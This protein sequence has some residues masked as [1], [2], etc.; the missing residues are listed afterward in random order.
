[1]TAPVLD[2]F[3]ERVA[4]D[5]FWKNIDRRGPNECWPWKAGLMSTGYGRVAVHREGGRY[6]YVRAHRIAWALVNGPIPT[7]MFICHHCDNRPCCN[8][9]H[10]F[11]GTHADNLADAVLKGRQKAAA[12]MRPYPLGTSNP[13][14]KLTPEDVRAIR[15]ERAGGVSVNALSRRYHVS[16][17]SIEDVLLGRTWRS[18]S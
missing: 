7:G 1:M 8:P 9:A 4:A 11:P 17:G 13:R 3:L 2:K 16:W 6:S 10:L 5:V 12:R 18:V 15:V 14:A